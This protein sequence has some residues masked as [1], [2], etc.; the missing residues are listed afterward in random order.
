MRDQP[1]IP[2]AVAARRVLDA[3]ALA[4]RPRRAT[5]EAVN[6][7]REAP[8]LGAQVRDHLRLGGEGVRHGC[9]GLQ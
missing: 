9:S 2:P 8:P 6:L 7:I 1:C 4:A 5:V 3:L